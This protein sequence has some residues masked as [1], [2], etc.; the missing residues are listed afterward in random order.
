MAKHDKID[1]NEASVDELTQIPG[2]GQKTAQAIIDFRES[3]GRID[4]ISDLEDAE[5]INPREIDNL[6]EWLTTGSE[7]AEEAEESEESEE[8]GW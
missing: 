8:E 7:G 1:V 2:M 3:H 5:Q 6:R 4:D